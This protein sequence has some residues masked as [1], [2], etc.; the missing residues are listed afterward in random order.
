MCGFGGNFEF[1]S[2]ENWEQISVGLQYYGRLLSIYLFYIIKTTHLYMFDVFCK[3][4][5]SLWLVT[6]VHIMLQR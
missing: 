2:V 6:S 5:L 1:H 3:V 4:E